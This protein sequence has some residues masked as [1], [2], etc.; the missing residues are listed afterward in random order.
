MS[1]NFSSLKGIILWFYR[2]K[3]NLKIVFKFDLGLLNAYKL[4]YFDRNNN[5]N[6]NGKILD[7]DY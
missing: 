3:I 6:M 2:L 5:G 4:M 7:G 1:V